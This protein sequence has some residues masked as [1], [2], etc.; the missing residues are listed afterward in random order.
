MKGDGLFVA[1]EEASVEMM[2]VS[3]KGCGSYGLLVSSG[4]SVKATQCEF[5]ENK[6]PGGLHNQ[7][8]AAARSDWRQSLLP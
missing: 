2:G 7:T 1:G 5:S 3:V 4:A 6:A 8:A